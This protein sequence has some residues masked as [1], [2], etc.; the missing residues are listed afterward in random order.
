MKNPY[1]IDWLN[2]Q[3]YIEAYTPHQEEVKVI[4]ISLDKLEKAKQGKHWTL[5]RKAN[6]F[7][8]RSI[9]IDDQGN[10]KE[11]YLHRFLTDCPDDLVV[12]HLSGDTLDNRNENLRICTRQANN[13]NANIRK[14]NKTGWKGVTIKNGKF[15]ASIRVNKKKKHLGTFST[16]QEAV[17][18]YWEASWVYHPH[19]D[20]NALPF[21]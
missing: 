4:T 2:N 5:K 3:V 15:V 21:I 1:Q 11:I 14:D 12:D 19:V 20:K 6:S 13:Q 16:L 9:L 17:A 8:A 7:Y 18:A 10:R